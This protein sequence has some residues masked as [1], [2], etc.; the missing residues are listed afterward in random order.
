MGQVIERAGVRGF[1]RDHYPLPLYSAR[2]TRNVSRLPCR[3]HGDYWGAFE[4]WILLGGYFKAVLPQRGLN[5]AKSAVLVVH[6]N[7]NLADQAPMLFTDPGQN[8]SLAPLDV[9]F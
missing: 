7:H 1:A 2:S 8:F 4:L 5:L 6:L 9:H 3:E